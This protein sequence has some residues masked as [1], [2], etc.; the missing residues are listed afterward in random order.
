MSG[1]PAAAAVVTYL[2][3]C[4]HM[5]C[6][7]V[8]GTSVMGA[9]TK[10]SVNTGLL[11]YFGAFGPNVTLD[12]VIEDVGPRFPPSRFLLRVD[13]GHVYPLP[14]LAVSKQ[15]HSWLTQFWIMVECLRSHMAG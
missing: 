14:S 11:Y 12:D 2:W 3:R 5:L 9:A 6:Y 4:M 15:A 13:F 1:H 7:A 10:D 8:R